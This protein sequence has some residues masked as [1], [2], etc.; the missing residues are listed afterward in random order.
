VLETIVSGA[1]SPFWIR[2]TKSDSA[3]GPTVFDPPKKPFFMKYQS[4]D[5]RYLLP[6]KGPSKQS[7]KKI[8]IVAEA[9]PD[10]LYYF[11]H[12]IIRVVSATQVKESLIS[13]TE[14]EIPPPGF[15]KRFRALQS[16]L[17]A[18]YLGSP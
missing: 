7:I 4:A 13:R 18:Q 10:R 6:I 9:L 11:Q 14:T 16:G 2:L 17:A 15:T 12:P 3:I 8:A 5:I 1:I